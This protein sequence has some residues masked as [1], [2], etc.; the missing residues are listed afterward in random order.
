MHVGH[1]VPGDEILEK[2]RERV[3]GFAASR[4]G[5]ESAEDVA[6]EVLILLHEKYPHVKSLDE[7]L[8]LSFRIVRFKMLALRRKAVRRG[9]TTQVAADEIPLIDPRRDPA[10]TAEQRE[11]RD[12]LIRAVLQLGERCRR[13]FA[14]KLEGKG[15][16]EIQA[17]LGAASIN[18]VYTWDFRCRKGLMARM[19]GG[20]EPGV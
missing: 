2:L 3:A 8:P 9:E 19:G 18:T 7:L 20:W 6:Q 13:I 10:A 16:A 15:F 17:V 12:R 1:G 4:I 5:R 11:T 14:L